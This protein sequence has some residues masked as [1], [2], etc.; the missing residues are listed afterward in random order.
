MYQNVRELNQFY[1]GTK[2][3]GLARKYLSDKVLDFWG[4]TNGLT[5]AGYGFAVPVMAPLIETSRRGLILMP[6]QICPTG[7]QSPGA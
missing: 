3:G 7:W 2:L 1:N 5:V 4:N 6:Q